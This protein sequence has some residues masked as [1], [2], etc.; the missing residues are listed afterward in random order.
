MPWGPPW[1]ASRTW[2]CRQIPHAD[3]AGL[4]LV[5]PGRAK[6]VVGTGGF[7]STVD[8]IQYGLGE[9]P[10]V[11]AVAEARSFT[12]GNLGGEA[13]WPRFGPRAGRL[14]V[15]SALS[16][17]LLR[18]DGT[19]LGALN[20]YAH[21]RDSFDAQAVR[22]GEAF[23]GPAAVRVTNAALLAQAERLVAQLTDALGS[24]A[25]I[26]QAL[27]IVMS[28]S[29]S[30]AE[31]AFDRLRQLSQGSQTKLLDVARDVIGQ[32]TRRAR[33]RHVATSDGSS[34]PDAPVAD[35]RDD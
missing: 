26:D 10:C 27:G 28:R 15:H 1:S 9:G 12:S 30:T 16:L 29:G 32:A 22:L 31:E 20:V 34:T 5:E 33:A 8:D 35:P 3:G 17:P 18:P 11:S 14:G 23:A 4:T 13:G 6:V 7:V 2:R 24:R 25:E 21:R 19:A